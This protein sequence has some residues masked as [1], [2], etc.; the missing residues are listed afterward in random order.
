MMFET[1]PGS[2]KLIDLFAA[3]VANPV[4]NSLIYEVYKLLPNDTD[5]TIYRT[6]GVG[7]FNFAFSNS[8]SLYHSERDNLA[9]LDRRSLQHHGDNAF[10]LTAALADT[11]LAALKSSEEASYFDLWGQTLIVWPAAL[12]LP[13][14]LVALAAIA[15]LIVVRRGAFSFA[16][17]A[18][19]VG[20]V[21][22]VPLLLFA[23]GWLLSYPL[24]VWPG[25]HPIDH[26]QPWPA[27]IALAAAAIFVALAVATAVRRIDTP[28]LVLVTW[29]VLAG[30]AVAVAWFV[31]GA[32]FLLIW[33]VLAFALVGWVEAATRRASTLGAAALV[34]FVAIAFFWVP[35]LLALE[36]VLSFGLSEFK[37]LVMTPFVLALV[38]VLAASVKNA[39]A[40]S[41]PIAAL[42]LAVVMAAAAASQT[43]AYAVDHP[44]G[45]N[46]TYY[47]D[48]ST[49]PRWLVG[50][51]GAPDAAYLQAAGFPAKEEDYLQFGLFESR[52][53]FKPATDLKLDPPSLVIDEVQTG[54]KLSIARG[55]LH[56]GRGGLQLAL[57]VAPKSGVRSVRFAGQEVI[58][59]A[60]LARDEPATARIVGWGARDIPVEIAFDPNGPTEV[61]LIERSALPESAE[62]QALLDARPKDAAPVHSGNSAIVIVKRDLRGSAPRATPSAPPAR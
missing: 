29:F 53:R 6:K 40:R 50:F 60:R 47:D 36:L 38:P 22:A 58:D 23:V 15:V 17:A 16:A 4:A 54:D 51:V 39:Q 55:V 41:L 49:A 35:Y 37:I 46:L 42:G 19:A 28:V 33:P 3:S 26:P 25:A 34:A 11:D 12:N 45:L 62:T 56:G 30:L 44:R 24:G 5:F 21:I 1:G 43:P 52:G 48:R 18:I 61:L 57:G 14:A 59:D 10:A 27:R 9:N 31:T 8:A 13:L 20:V 7:G 32:S 2:A